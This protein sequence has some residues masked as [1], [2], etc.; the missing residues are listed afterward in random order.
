METKLTR[1]IVKVNTLYG[2]IIN[3]YSDLGLTIDEFSLETLLLPDVNFN[4]YQSI[5]MESQ[6]GIE[7]ELLSA[8]KFYLE[9]FGIDLS[10][11]KKNNEGIWY[12]GEH[13]FY[14]YQ[15]AG[16]QIGVEI[17]G[18]CCGATSFNC[19]EG[20]FVLVIGA[21][22]V[23]ARG[24]YG[25]DVGENIPAGSVIFY[26]YYVFLDEYNNKKVYHFRSNTPSRTDVNVPL[27]WNLD[28]YDYK[29][30]YWGISIGS[31]VITR[32]NLVI[33][34]QQ[35]FISNTPTLVSGIQSGYSQIGSRQTRTT[36]SVVTPGI[37]NIPLIDQRTQ[38]AVITPVSVPTYSP[39]I[40][41]E[42]VN[43]NKLDTLRALII[44]R[45][46][47]TFKNE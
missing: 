34:Q 2:K 25:T 29:N 11:F 38:N 10:K 33:N 24:E 15:K 16:N 17:G 31:S 36:T 27:T 42:L 18:N 39:V 40:K 26:G 6:Q 30:N 47:I 28:V 9:K 35:Q 20:G 43:I 37:S 12:S 23:I 32:V 1:R 46:V 44:S 8:T 14:P 13:R 41:Q 7:E 5:L 19:V 3:I 21:P 4:F 45:N 22:G